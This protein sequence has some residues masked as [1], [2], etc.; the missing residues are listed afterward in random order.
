M[1]DGVQ[2]LGWCTIDCPFTHEEGV[3]DAPD[4]YAYDGGRVK[5]W[6]CSPHDY[7]EAWRVGDVIGVCLDLDDGTITF[8]R[9]GRSLGVAFSGSLVAFFLGGGGETFSTVSSRTLPPMV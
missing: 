7:G 8:Y 5:R 1:T 3:G 2:Q 9:N 4:S 6:N